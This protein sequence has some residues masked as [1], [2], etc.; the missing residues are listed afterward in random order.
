MTHR[1]FLHIYDVSA[2]ELGEILA[3][4]QTPIDQLGYP[5]R[6]AGVAMIFEK[7]SNRTRHSME[8]AVVQLGGHPVY[9]RGEEVGFDVR[10]SVED[11][12]QVMAGYHSL[13]CARVFDHG[14]LLRMAA[15]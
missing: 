15:V 9:T 5:L 10:E 11:I 8:M 2:H 3:L 13:L 14:V 4:A 6:G 1:N 12:T 7:P